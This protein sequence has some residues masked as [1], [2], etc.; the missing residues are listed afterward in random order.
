MVKDEI[1]GDDTWDVIKA[2]V[3]VEI[4]AKSIYYNLRHVSLC[5]SLIRNDMPFSVANWRG[6]FQIIKG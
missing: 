6:L 3:F 4:S 5:R 1:K 2:H